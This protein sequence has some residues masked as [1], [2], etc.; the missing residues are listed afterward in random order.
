VE[1]SALAQALALITVSMPIQLPGRKLCPF[2]FSR[3]VFCHINELRQLKK[4]SKKNQ[5][6]FTRGRNCAQAGMGWQY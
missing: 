2:I 3:F 6:H 5:T 1:I 4:G